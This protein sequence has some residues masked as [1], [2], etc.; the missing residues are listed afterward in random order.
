MKK[1]TLFAFSAV[2]MCA[3]SMSAQVKPELSSSQKAMFTKTMKQML[4]SKSDAAM[5]K[6]M[7]MMKAQTASYMPSK[8][9]D[10][11]KDDGS[12][13]QQNVINNTYD[14]NGN[15]TLCEIDGY[16]TIYRMTYS[17]D[18]NGNLTSVYIESSG[19][20]GAS[21]S[22]LDHFV[23]EYDPM[24]TSF[25]TKYDGKDEYMVMWDAI[26]NINPYVKDFFKYDL[27]RDS[28]NRVTQSVYSEKSEYDDD[29]VMEER[30]TYTYGSDGKVTSCTTEFFDD[31]ELGMYYV[32]SNIQ[33][34]TT[35]NQLTGSFDTWCEGNN[36]IKSADVN[37]M[38]FFNG[39]LTNTVQDNG[40][41]NLVADLSIA[42]M[43]SSK[44]ITDA[45]GSYESVNSLEYQ[46]YDDDNSYEKVICQYD[47]HG[48]IVL[49]ES[50]DGY[51]ADNN[52]LDGGAKAEYT[53]HDEYGVPARMVGYEWE[54]G[55]GYQSNVIY[56]T[57]EYVAIGASGISGV[58]ADTDMGD[59]TVYSISGVETGKS[60][61]NLPKGIYIV[62]S[63]NNTKKVVLK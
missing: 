7:K 6:G 57:Q 13:Y 55:L 29:F 60:L 59:M 37:V 22:E 16:D 19:N 31:G 40:S 61:D 39:T 54:D 3:T 9:Y 15:L 45:N 8:I 21:W 51:T 47:D 23:F 48:N 33:W 38:G 36:V 32:F 20:N 35:D 49:I 58:K 53:Y 10:Y 2:L 24:L 41:Y 30:N 1:F 46:G 63:G 18:A 27:T 43:K 12:W 25:V 5:K 62:K 52:E 17:Y 42:E 4:S 50:Y 44:T 28:Q 26:Y 34:Y 11:A 14:D 56:E